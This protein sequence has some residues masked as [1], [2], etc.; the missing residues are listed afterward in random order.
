MDRIDENI[1][2][3]KAV[4]RWENEGIDILGYS[5][6]SNAWYKISH[7]LSHWERVRVRA[8]ADSPLVGSARGVAAR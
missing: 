5:E 4:E 7:P 1:D 6:G 2:E 3:R 8:Y